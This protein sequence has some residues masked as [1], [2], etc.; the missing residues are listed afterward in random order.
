[1]KS[2]IETD[3]NLFCLKEYIDDERFSNIVIFGSYIS[4]KKKANDI[5]I[6]FIGDLFRLTNFHRRADVF[7]LKSNK[8]LDLFCYTFKEFKTLFDNNHEFIKNIKHSFVNI[9]GDFNALI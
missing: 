2:L 7:N 5:D 8:Y 6:L 9:K 4:K 3:K 1:M